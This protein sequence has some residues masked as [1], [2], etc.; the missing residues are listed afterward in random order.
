MKSR[1]FHVKI[2]WTLL[3]WLLA[4]GVAH[5]GDISKGKQH[6][7]TNCSVCHGQT[8]RSVMVGA[9]NFDRGESLLRSDRSLLGQIREGKNACPAYRGILADQDIFDVIAYLRTLH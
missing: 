8:G 1:K 6:Y 4:C 2:A 7:D 9:P 5:A 3:P